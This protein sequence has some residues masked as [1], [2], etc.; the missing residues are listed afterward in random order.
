MAA[1]PPS[2]GNFPPSISCAQDLTLDS[3]RST[4]PQ[5]PSTPP[6]PLALGIPSFAQLIGVSPSTVEREIYA[7][8]LRSIHI[9]GRRLIP[10]A[11]GER[12]LRRKAEEHDG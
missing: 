5:R 12:Y 9:R 6:T 11:E 1:G 10:Y 4:A 2:N 3:M 7:G 8:R